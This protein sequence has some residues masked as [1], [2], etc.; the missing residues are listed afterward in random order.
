M[1]PSRGLRS[2]T[3]Y[4]M[5][6]AATTLNSKRLSTIQDLTRFRDRLPFTGIAS[7]VWRVQVD[8]QAPRFLVK[9]LAFNAEVSCGERAVTWCFAQGAHDLLP[10][11]SLERS[12]E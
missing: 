8:S 4:V 7:L 9:R 5:L 11:H 3:G 1:S 2:S 10:F 12:E 6:S